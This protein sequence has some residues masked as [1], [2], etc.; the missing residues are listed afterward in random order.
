MILLLIFLSVPFFSYAV[1]WYETFNSSYGHVLEK[2]SG[3]KPAFWVL[4]GIFSSFVTNTLVLA[5]L[6]LG[7][8][9]RLWRP[10]ITA[11]NTGPAVVLVHGLY[12]NAGAWILYRKWLRN[13]GYDRIYAFSYGSWKSDFQQIYGR[14]ENWMAQVKQECPDAPIVMIGHSLGGLLARNYAVNHNESE[15][16]RVRGIITLGTPFKGSKMVAFG[17]GALAADLQFEGPLILELANYE[18]PSGLHAAAI[19]SPVDNMVLPTVSLRPPDQ[20]IE[21]RT[22]PLCHVALLCHN[23]TFR[24]VLGHMETALSK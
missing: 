23:R 21:E 9:S 15:H 11:G 4:R 19:Y 20:W 5:L 13:R 16:N 6:P 8:F 22:S 1:F 3:G 24:R 12:H 10:G 7:W 2:I 18:I 17:F 14:F